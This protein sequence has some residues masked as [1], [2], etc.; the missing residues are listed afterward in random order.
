MRLI[1]SLWIASL[2]ISSAPATAQPLQVEVVA[3][4]APTRAATRDASAASTVFRG[5]ELTR[6]GADAADVVSR[7]AGVQVSRTG[8]SSDVATASIR[9][10]TSA[11]T[12][13]YLAGIRLNDEITGTADLSAVPL[14][15]LD[16]V[17]VFRGNAP[18]EADRLGLGGAIFFEPKLPRRSE[19]GAGVELGSFGERASWLAASVAAAGSAALVSLRHAQADND[20]PYVSDEGQSFTGPRVT[21]ERRNADVT[22]REAWAV[23]R[24]ALGNRGAR[25]VTVLNTLWREQGESGL[26]VIQADRGRSTTQ[27]LLAGLSAKLPCAVGAASC[28]L[29]LGTS[30]LLAQNRTADP[31]YELSL[32]SEEITNDGVRLTQSARASVWPSDSARITAHIA[33]ERETLHLQR[34][35]RERSLQAARE[36]TRLGAA[37]ELASESRLAVNALAAVA[38]HSTTDGSQAG[39]GCGV[40]AL[41]GRAGA[42]W[43]ALTGV[44]VIANIGRYVRVP[45]LGELFGVAPLVR[46]NSELDPESGINAD[47]GVRVT[48]A[49]Q[50]AIT[51]WADAFAFARWTRDLVTYQRA[52]QGYARPY[53]TERV[54][55]IGVELSSSVSVL[56]HFTNELAV[57]VSDP[58]ETT[59]GRTTLNDVLP[60]RSRL[61][62]SETAEVHTS[63]PI[64]LVS[65][66]RAAFGS[67]V[68]YRS[69]MAADPAALIIVDEQFWFDVYV[70]LSFVRRKLQLR[71]AVENVLNERRQDLLNLPLP[72]RSF[73]A[74]VESWW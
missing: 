19:L 28:E 15:M 40:F 41:E 63:A 56:E 17:E 62:V 46:G 27:R 14:F 44:D 67:Q 2:W 49:R 70:A 13:V 36:V 20:Y 30:A 60:Y 35:A 52:A 42:R 72:G 68:H 34:R 23:G 51:V 54:R 31:G 55:T 3:E 74:S 22:T 66:D 61:L 32:G 65:L 6:P 71:A 59:P 10:A 53:N 43:R 45:T 33:R 18:A 37:A 16:R 57:T 25:I 48:S 8:T 11:Q 47:I 73:H 7:A 58:R 4:R 24:H 5:E 64:E 50:R 12:P 39:H 29:E 21:R 9:G 38:C 1:P 26:G 69:S